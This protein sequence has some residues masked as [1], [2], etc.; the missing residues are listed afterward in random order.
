MD[1]RFKYV[2]AHFTPSDPLAKRNFGDMFALSRLEFDETGL[3]VKGG[4]GWDMYR[5]VDK[6][7]PDGRFSSWEEGVVSL[8]AQG[9]S[10]D[11][12]CS[13]FFRRGEGPGEGKLCVTG[14]DAVK[15][16]FLKRG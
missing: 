3:F 9:W 7:A 13:E 1:R 14:M 10:L 16:F 5:L 6:D 8:A 15:A 2:F 4:I 11:Q 12:D